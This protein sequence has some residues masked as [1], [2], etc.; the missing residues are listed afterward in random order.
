MPR[1]EQGITSD[2]YM[3]IPRT[4]IF[5]RRGES[6]L[7]I[8]GAGNKRLWANKYNGVGGHVELGEDI[9]S[10]AQRELLEETG[11]SVDLVLAGIITVNT[12]ENIGI[13][14]FVFSGESKNG[15]VKSSREG[16]LEW[17][18]INEMSSFPLVEDVQLFLERILKMKLG[19]PPFF[20]HSHYPE[21]DR[22]SVRFH[23]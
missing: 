15:D 3:L 17:V 5:I 2:R 14:V 7:L 6:F 23:S 18:R 10:S 16:S 13:V 11:L 21:D 9:Y 1:S 22:L 19:D 12:G 20:A 4:L 8:K